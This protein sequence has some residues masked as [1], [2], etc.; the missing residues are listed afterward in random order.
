MSWSGLKLVI[1]SLYVLFVEKKGGKYSTIH[2]LSTGSPGIFSA[3]DIPVKAQSKKQKGEFKKKK[4]KKAACLTFLQ[5][6]SLFRR[7]PL[8]GFLSDFSLISLQISYIFPLMK[9]KKINGIKTYGLF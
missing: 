1:V 2:Q 9:K 7:Y 4:E 8:G 3:Q 5:C 6:N